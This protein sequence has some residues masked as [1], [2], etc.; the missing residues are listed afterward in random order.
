MN[1][2]V[3]LTSV[4]ICAIFD[5]LEPHEE[6]HVTKE[7]PEEENSRQEFQQDGRVIL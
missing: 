3:K 2:A 4:H 6:H 1:G 7:G 5:P